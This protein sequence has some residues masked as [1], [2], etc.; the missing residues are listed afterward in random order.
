[1]DAI[2]IGTSSKKLGS[3]LATEL[4][5]QAIPVESKIFPDGESYIRIPEGVEKK[6]IAV[7]QSTYQPQDKHLIELFLIIDALD[8]LKAK[9]VTVIVP[10]LAYARQDKRFKPG[11]AISSQTIIR[12]IE[13]MRTHHFFT[14]NIHKEEILSQFT[15]P[16][17]NISTMPAIADYIQS[18]DFKNPLILSP[19]RGGAHLAEEVATKTHTDFAVFE[20]HRDRK[21]GEVRTEFKKLEVH[22]REVVI[23][24]DIISTGST[25]ANVAEIVKKQGAK[26]VITTCAHPILASGALE[27]MKMA[28]I[29][30]VLGTD[31]VESPISKI[32]VAPLLAQALRKI[33]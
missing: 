33:P 8:A 31:C 17:F 32:T 13:H 10:Y 11:E 5:V 26:Y 28:G 24:D 4:G 18:L 16:A 2:V 23:V 25:I 14:C 6:E 30:M 12:I 29:D 9:T 7:V 20:K 22:N 15:I 1:M 3:R 21:T 19:D 27:R